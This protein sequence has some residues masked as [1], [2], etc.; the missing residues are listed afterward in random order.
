MLERM[1]D[2]IIQMKE[3]ECHYT[4]LAKLIGEYQKC[5]PAF[6]ERKMAETF[7]ISKT[8]IN[9]LLMIARLNPSL[10]E[11]AV[12]YRVEKY[13]LLEANKFLG[14]KKSAA[15]ASVL[16]GTLTKRRQLRLLK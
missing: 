3:Q 16:N 9:R 12:R 6:T 4:V 7:G 8:E 15:F 14:R 13:V 1:R 11:A 10:H 2:E 5:S